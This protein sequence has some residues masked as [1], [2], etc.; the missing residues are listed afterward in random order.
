MIMIAILMYYFL[1][2]EVFRVPLKLHMDKGVETLL[3]TEA[4]HHFYEDQEGREMEV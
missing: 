2:I 1:V 4:Q 3:M